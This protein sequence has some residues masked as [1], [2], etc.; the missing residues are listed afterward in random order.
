[1]NTNDIFEYA[2]DPETSV[3]KGKPWVIYVVD[4]DEGVLKT[5]KDTLEYFT[6]KERAVELFFLKMQRML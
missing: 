3:I 4:D 6:Y 1:M 5:T 2:K